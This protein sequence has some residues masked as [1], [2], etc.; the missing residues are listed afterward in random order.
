MSCWRNCSRTHVCLQ[1]FVWLRLRHGTATHTHMGSLMVPHSR[2]A[3]QERYVAPWNYT[4]HHSGQELEVGPCS[5]QPSHQIPLLGLDF[6]R[7]SHRDRVHEVRG[8]LG[9]ISYS[10]F[11]VR[12]SPPNTADYI[13]FYRS[14][15][16]LIAL[17][18]KGKWQSSTDETCRSNWKIWG[19]KRNVFGHFL[20]KFVTA[21]SNTNW[22]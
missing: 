12:P 9:L 21:S 15:V 5:G 17:S 3:T 2:K 18:L 10:V 13:L 7:I 6:S 16:Q 19:G 11:V 22:F 8:S 4:V 20:L 14:A 1:R